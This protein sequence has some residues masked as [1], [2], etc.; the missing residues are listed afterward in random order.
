VRIAALALAAT[1]ALAASACSREPSADERAAWQAEIANLTAQADALQGRLRALVD[2]DPRYAG[3]PAGDV[4]IAVPT[5]FLDALVQRVFSDVARRVDLTLSGIETHKQKTLKKGIPIGD[6]SVDLLVEKV[7]GRLGPGT[8][9][10]VFGGDEV[11]LSLPVDVIEGTGEASLHVRWKGR[12]V[13]GAVCGDLDLRERVSGSVVRATYPLAGTLRFSAQGAEILATPRFPETKLQLR[14]APSPKTWARIDAIVASQT[15][16]CKWVLEQVDV[17][18]LLAKQ[19]Q[20]KGFGVKLPLHKIEPFRFPAG[21]SESVTVRGR[22]LALDVKAETVR[23][24]DTAVWLGARVG[25]RPVA[26]TAV[27]EGS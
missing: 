10:V 13:A 8:P 26:A 12:N 4:V 14:V 11:T 24:D 1:L 15:G 20:E 25:V 7:N 17:K 5:A 3:V 23:I 18:K 21:L 9:K 19:F 16:L 6:V 27:P 22:P 2:A